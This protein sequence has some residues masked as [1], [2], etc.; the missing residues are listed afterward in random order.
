[1]KTNLYPQKLSNLLIDF[2]NLG[3]ISNIN[4]WRKP[5][6]ALF[7]FFIS[8]ATVFPQS[9]TQLGANI[10][11]QESYSLLGYS[12]SMSADG[13]TIIAGGTGLDQNEEDSGYA[14]VLIWNGT[15]WIQ[16][17]SDL[18]GEAFEDQFGYSVSISSDGNTIA[19]GAIQDDDDQLRLGYAKIYTWNG[20]SWILKGNKISGE[21]AYDRFGTSISL[22]SD[23]NTVAV[24]SRQGASREEEGSVR[25]FTWNGSVWTQIGSD[26][27]GVEWDYFGG[28]IS[29]ASDGNTLAVGAAGGNAIHGYARLYNWS[30]TEWVQKGNDLVGD[31]EWD[32]FGFSVSI[33]DDGNTVA[34]GAKE[35]DGNGEAS[36]QLKVFNWNGSSWVQKGNDIYGQAA[37]D[38]FGWSVGLNSNG[39]TVAVGVTPFS[40]NRGWSNGNVR[41]YTWNNSSWEQVG[42][43]MSG[44][45]EGDRAG[46][47]TAINSDGSIVA[48]AAPFVGYVKIY[49]YMYTGISGISDTKKITIHPNPFISLATIEYELQQR[50]EVSLSIYN[51]LGQRIYQTQETQQQ[52]KQKF[53]WNAEGY[54]DGIYY[55]R[56]QVGEQVA[57]GKMVKVR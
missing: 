18:Y 25:V 20:T 48:M 5:F 47:V 28:S 37:Y 23:G 42:E 27:D 10:E 36:G 40:T 8:V 52:G 53:I 29:L 43:E 44:D 30:G 38:Y 22:S 46:Y 3:G 51:H 45:T 39:N 16:K 32:R 56:L 49:S 57:N 2:P 26:L 35:N 11:G 55:Y 17:G 4:F 21:N 6:F 15:S 1:M 50:E 9:W 12:V 24:S 54:A 41:V 33:S 14:K 13:Y 19:V 31:A 7:L 34:I